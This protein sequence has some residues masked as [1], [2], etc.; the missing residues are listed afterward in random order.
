M[1]FR[2][3][4]L[5]ALLLGAIAPAMGRVPKAQLDQVVSSLA[6]SGTIE[7]DEQG[8]IL[9]YTIKDAEAYDQAVRD[10]LD[11]NIARWSFKPVFVDGVARRARF[12]MYLRLEAKP[13]DDKRFEVT[14]ASAAFG[15]KAPAVAHAQIASR[16]RIA[17]TYPT[18]ENA[19]GVG[20][21]VVTVLKVGRDGRVEDVLVEQTNLKAVGPANAMKQWRADLERVSVAAARKWTFDVPTTGPRAEWPYW[22][23]RV[24][25]TF[26]PF[27]ASEKSA[28][29]QW[30]SYV[31]GPRQAV[32]WARDGEKA[33]Q[34]GDALP[35]GRAFPLE[36]P[37]HL[38]TALNPG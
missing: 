20:G 9:G 13:L 33:D 26:V 2:H 27:G 21:S 6:V 34:N 1:N 38:L 8:K 15:S 16:D 31:P 30:E 23:M 32:K 35:G 17:P 4:A 19:L 5:L 3:I 18:N 37:L 29:G 11:R 25:F 14:I 28:P 22:L 12:D 10:L 24:P 7:V 36:Q